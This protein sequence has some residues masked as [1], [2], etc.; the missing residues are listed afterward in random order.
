ML[1]A[2]RYTCRDGRQSGA[3][4][5]FF[6]SLPCCHPQVVLPKVKT[7]PTSEENIIGRQGSGYWKCNYEGLPGAYCGPGL[8]GTEALDSKR[9]PFVPHNLWVFWSEYTNPGQTLQW[10]LTFRVKSKVLIMDI[11]PYR[12]GLPILL[13]ILSLLSTHFQPH[14]PCCSL[15]MPAC[16]P[17]GLCT[18]YSLCVEISSL[19]ALPCSVPH[20]RQ[21][22]V[23]MLP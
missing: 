22:S 17:Q 16:Q 14:W 15:N 13:L 4:A 5:G 21:A 18:L 12:L 1:K 8:T 11:R 23:Q 7:C 20:F 19:T 10:P 6:P 9:P 2:Q 3:P